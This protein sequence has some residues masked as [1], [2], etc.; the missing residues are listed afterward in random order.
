ME[1]REGSEGF[2]TVRLNSG[3]LTYRPGNRYPADMASDIEWIE[4]P[5]LRDPV[6]VLAFEGWN[7][8][9]DA[10]SR[11]LYYLMEHHDE[12]PVAQIDMETYVN[13]QLSRPVASIEGS[14][15]H[16][17]WPVTGFFA[18]PLPDHHRD[19]VLVL[20]EEPH[21][22][23]RRYCA[24][25]VRA[26]VRLGVREAVALGAFIG[27]VPHTLP[28][29]L[30]GSSSD[31]GFALRM[32]INVSTYEG[33]TGITGVITSVLEDE[34]IEA[35]GLWAGIP[36]YLAG[37]PSPT[38]TRALLYAL[39][40]LIGWGFDTEELDAEVIRYQGKIN[41]IIGES[42]GLSDY[43]RQLEEESE[44]RAVQEGEGRRLVED[45]EH[46]LRNPN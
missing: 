14:V 4:E 15:R 11:V 24:E 22:R 43:I 44:S 35:S 30:F 23:W 1:T 36:H 27:Q 20:G 9:A 29:P 37:T 38:G 46:F 45:I 12:I 26:F 33:P 13:Y 2:R 17:H 18:M 28:V 6:G 8:A 31:P 16:V 41:E 3:L 42:E 10:A 5:P 19:L 21:L 25:V 7:D 34:G 40:D 39:G 32:G